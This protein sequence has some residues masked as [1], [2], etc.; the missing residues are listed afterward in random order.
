MA[1][2]PDY[3]VVDFPLDQALMVAIDW[4]ERHCI[5]PDGFF[6]GDPFA[7][8]GW[9]LHFLVNHYR[10]R[11][12]AAWVPESP[13]LGSAFVYRR[14]QI[15]MP[16]K[17]G[18]APLTAAQICLEGVGPALF[19]GWARGDEAWV[20]ADH[21]CGCGWVYEYQPGEAMGM[22]WPTPLIQVTATSKE[23]TDNVWDALR[24]MIDDGPL[25]EVV[26]KTGEEFIRLPGHGR[27]DVVTSSATSRLGQRVT[28][29]PQDETGLWLPSNGMV[30]VADT[31]NRGLAGMGGRSVET[32]NAW[33]PR[34]ES[35]ARTTA[36]SKA[37][38]IFR[39][40]PLPP[41]GLD[42]REPED[43][44][45]IHAIV[46]SGS[47]WVD[48]DSIDAMAVELLER[49]PGQAE[50]FFGNRPTAGEGKAFDVD[51][52]A[53]LARPGHE[54]PRGALVVIGFDGSKF[55]DASAMVATEVETGHQWPLGIWYPG[56]FDD[57]EIDDVVVTATLEEA[58]DRFKVLRVYCDPP[59][60]E[61]T[62]DAW[63]G[64]WHSRIKKWWTN[65]P[66]QMA[67]ALRAYHEAMTESVVAHDGDAVFA[68]HIGNATK[69][70]CNVKDDEGRP[71]WLIQKEAPKSPMKIDAA[72]AGC[73]SWEARGDAIAA[74]A[75]RRRRGG[76]FSM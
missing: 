14:S 13:L 27:I 36:A 61:D 65:R 20:C 37:S 38:D 71:M 41:A 62:V 32:T 7:L 58:F 2:G 40:H 1:E 34:L 46:Y 76:G 68:E 18:K 39:L 59:R 24:P 42:Y 51:R 49:D 4:I 33:D 6:A 45:R 3:S 9:Q 52:W 67:W 26:P 47:P 64:R 17:A 12:D 8:V 21:G 50:R 48:L 54:V 75:L 43:R 44:R 69:A 73:L 19:A 16:Q 53:E 10:V 56:D 63:A 55:D 60:W 29:V 22:P 66:R 11:P 28:F 5:V 30:K 23:Q 25:H 57:E 72:M 15:V 70:V 31:Q 74:G 35:V